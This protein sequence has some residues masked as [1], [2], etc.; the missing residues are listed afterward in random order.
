[1][2]PKDGSHPMAVYEDESHPFARVDIIART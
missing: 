1:M 2:S